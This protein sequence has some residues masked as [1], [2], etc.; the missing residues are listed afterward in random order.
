MFKFTKL[1]H[2]HTHTTDLHGNNQAMFLPSQ[3]GYRN[4]KWPVLHLMTDGLDQNTKD[5]NDLKTS[6]TIYQFGLLKR[7]SNTPILHLTI[8]SLNID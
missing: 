7:L 2:T 6:F 4:R 5:R 3:T 1:T 8:H